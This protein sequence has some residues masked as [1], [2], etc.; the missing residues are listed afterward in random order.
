MTI[1]LNGSKFLCDAFDVLDAYWC[2][3]NRLYEKEKLE[4]VSKLSHIDNDYQVIAGLLLA[5]SLTTEMS[6]QSVFL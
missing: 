1:Y 4:S 6:A 3:K 5:A 2:K